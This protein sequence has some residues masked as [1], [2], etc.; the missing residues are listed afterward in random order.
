MSCHKQSDHTTTVSQ[1]LMKSDASPLKDS[2]ELKPS[3]SEDRLG[4]YIILL[5]K[6]T[7]AKYSLPNSALL[8]LTQNPVPA[9]DVGAGKG[10]MLDATPQWGAG[11]SDPFN[12]GHSDK[13]LRDSWF[14]E[15]LNGL[16]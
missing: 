13:N 4:Y 11:W 5:R 8:E 16:G 15:S 14:T 9:P 7:P 10:A 2:S 12:L 3:G 6:P 1:K